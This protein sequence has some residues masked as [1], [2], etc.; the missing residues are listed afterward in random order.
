MRIKQMSIIIN[1]IVVMQLLMSCHQ[2]AEPETYIIPE[3]FTGKVNII[4]NRK[5][6]SEKKYEN[7]RRIYEIP[8]DGVLLTQFTTNDGFINRKYYYKSQSGELKLLQTLE[9]DTTKANKSLNE[10]EVG[11]FLDGISGVYGNSGEPSAL[12][13]QEFVVSSYK[14]LDSFFTAE[15][16]KIFG[17]RIEQISG[18]KQ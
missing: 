15:Y 18:L 12:E 8:T 5:E 14:N 7:G 4:F 2:K 16:N 6:G 10:T 13:Y 9:A 11:I 17:R 1:L 3:S